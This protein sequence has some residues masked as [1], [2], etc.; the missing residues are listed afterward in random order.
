[1]KEL[2]SV[3]E[4]LK[5]V[6]EKV[7]FKEAIYDLSRRLTYRELDEESDVLAAALASWGVQKGDRVGVSLPNWHET[8]I[9][10]FAVAKIGAILVPFNP[11]Y[12]MHEVKHILEDAAPK[13]LFVSEMFDQNIGVEN[14]KTLVQDIVSI[15][16]SKQGTIPFYEF[17]AYRESS[18]PDVEIDPEHDIYAILY[19]SGSTGLPK[20]AMLTHQNVTLSG[21]TIAKK[22]KS[23]PDDV[24]LIAPPLYHTFS[25]CVCLMGAVSSQ[26]SMVLQANYKAEE[27]LQLIESEKI[28][29]HHAIPTML[30]LE[31]NHPKFSSY[32]LS[33]LRVGV[34]GGAP[35]PAETVKQ[36][37]EKMGMKICAGY[38]LTEVGAITVT[39]YDDVIQNIMKTIGKPLPSVD[40]RIVNEERQPVPVGEVGEIAC[41]GFGIIKGYYNASEK[42][43]EVLDSEGWFY[44]GDLG[45]MDESGYVKCIGRKK[46]MIIRGGYNI[47]P[48]EIEEITYKHPMVAEAVVI[49]LPDPVMGESVCLII[50][51]KG[52]L[53]G[54]EIQEFI[55]QHLASYKV[56]SQVLFVDEFPLTASGKI[57]KHVLRDNLIQNNKVNINLSIS[58]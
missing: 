40:I 47:Y 42:T 3:S 48:R 7:P 49:G 16:F 58:N 32:D 2:I 55:K 8:V 22:V 44:T 29:V 15:R 21:I 50:K 57:Q 18:L 43:R 38:G 20:G 25:L 13:I 41:K 30:I 53:L 6:S 56:P 4:L 9:I 36:I 28:S 45:S 10:Y 5:S 19:T 31:L 46:E 17:H 51:P 52:Q 34:A 24:Y 14:I 33:S 26:A 11:K 39:D 54:E 1:M 37:R 27:A 12:R 35:C 23:F